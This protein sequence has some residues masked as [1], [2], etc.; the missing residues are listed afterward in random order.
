LSGDGRYVLKFIKHQRQESPFWVQCGAWV[1]PKVAEQQRARR[2]RKERELQQIYKSWKLAFER[3]REDAGLI[4]V[5]FGR[6]DQ[7]FGSV[8]LVTKGRERMEIPLDRLPFLIQKRSDPFNTAI[9]RLI[10]RG[11]ITQAQLLVDRLIDLVLAD[12]GRGLADHDR[13]I[14]RNSGV[15]KGR[16]LHIDV[17]SFVQNE[18]ARNPEVYGKDLFIKGTKMRLWLERLSP[19]VASHLEQRL[20]AV[21][22]ERYFDYTYVKESPIYEEAASGL[23]D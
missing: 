4:H 3:M 20:Q 10:K 6:T 9:E 12:Y 17:G 1:I 5:H 8:H 14:A 11:D 16:P 15:L 2:A 23:G 18:R 7:G 22:G 19:A 21:L 13:W